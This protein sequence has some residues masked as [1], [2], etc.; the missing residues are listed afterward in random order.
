M[1]PIE[2]PATANSESML[3][4][5]EQHGLRPHHVADGDDRKFQAP[6]LAGLRD[7]SRPGRVVPMQ[8]PTTFGQITK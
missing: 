1:P 2:P 4:V 8:P 5:V 6:R 7:W 3:E